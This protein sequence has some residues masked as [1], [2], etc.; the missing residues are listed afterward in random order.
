[1]VS[2]YDESAHSTE[3]PFVI[4]GDNAFPLQPN[5]MKP[6]AA[7]GLS[8][9][10]R[11]FNYRLSRSEDALENAFGIL[12]NIFRI[13]G[14]TINLLPEVVQIIVLASIVLHNMMRTK[15]SSHIDATNLLVEDMG[16]GALLGPFS[17][18]E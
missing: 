14:Q 8:D 10:G 17:L 6:F 9:R 12:V 13:F 11:I 7:K 4:F 15:S 1:M 2:Y 18:T 3:M 5:L 16:S